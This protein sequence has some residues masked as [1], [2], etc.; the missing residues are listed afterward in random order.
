MTYEQPRAQ[1]PHTLRDHPMRTLCGAKT[2]TGGSCKGWAMKNGRCRM[3]GGASLSGVASATFRH[4]RY[5]T[6]LPKGLRVAYEQG[7]S[8]PDLLDLSDEIAVLQLRC[9]ELLS[10]WEA[11][12]APIRRR[13]LQEQCR[14]LRAAVKRPDALAVEELMNQLDELINASVDDAARWDE[15]VGTFKVLGTLT[16][17]EA[18]R[19]IEMGQLVSAQHALGIF[20]ELVVLV[21]QHVQDPA[22]LRAIQ[23]GM[24]KLID[25]TDPIGRVG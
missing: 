17:Q 23:H 20:R 11:S 10:A 7:R 4:G 13:A 5:S 18:K 21:R 15:I 1:P 14:A 3:H 12:G 19:R 16:A 25:S 8:D 22:A 6:A 2:R 9:R 24:T